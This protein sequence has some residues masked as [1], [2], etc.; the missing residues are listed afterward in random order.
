MK[1]N[2][3]HVKHSRQ[4]LNGKQ[5]MF[6]DRCFTAGPNSDEIVVN[7]LC[8]RQEKASALGYF[9]YLVVALS[10]FYGL[11][12]CLNVTLVY[13]CLAGCFFTALIYL[14]FFVIKQ[15]IVT[16]IRST[17]VQLTTLYATGR[18]QTQ[19]IDL[20][21]ID[22]VVINEAVSMHKVVYYLAVL[23][24][25]DEHHQSLHGSTRV[26]PFF[27]HSM[28]RLDTLTDIYQSIHSVLWEDAE[29]DNI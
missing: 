14:H 12:S 25:S 19:F 10:C 13:L 3:L 17:G 9:L 6:V 7:E 11:A 18:R 29:K 26:L 28:P 4:N 8:L 1:S 22:D 5:V 2:N 24:K 16:V 20:R 15:E 27:L 23:L 21:H